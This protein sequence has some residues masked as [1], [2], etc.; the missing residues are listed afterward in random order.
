VHAAAKPAEIRLAVFDAVARGLVRD[1]AIADAAARLE[2]Q[3]CEVLDGLFADRVA[4]R[5]VRSAEAAIAPKAL[6]EAHNLALVQGVLLRAQEVTVDVREHLRSVVRY[7][8][9]RRL[10]VTGSVTEQGS[11]LTLSGPLALFHKT[12]RYGLAMAAFAPSV[13]V[14]PGFTLEARC[15]MRGESLRLR[16]SS[17]DPVGSSFAL[18]RATDSAVEKR[19]MRDVKRLGTAWEIRRETAAIV[20]GERLFF[21]DFSMERGDDR[22]FVEVVGFY[23]PEYLRAK[24]ASLK[25]AGLSRIVVC[26]DEELACANGE[27]A[28]PEVVRYRRRVDAGELVAA[29]ERAV[30][31]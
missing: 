18:P 14:T 1:E 21:P 4:E 28:A 26:I 27:I 31:R 25:A 8:K 23:M 11:R 20:A 2:I 5:K 29:V 15:E 3:A 10:I 12:T 7:A 16:V 17:G 13:F 30:A 6:C 9:L 22:V 24:L 19:L